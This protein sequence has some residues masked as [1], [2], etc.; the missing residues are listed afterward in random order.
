MTEQRRIAV[1]GAASNVG[2][3]PYDDGREARHLDTTAA[4]L[5]SLGVVGR[6]Q[7]DDLG[8]VPG[9]A[10]RDFQRPLGGVRNESE[11]AEYSRAL[12]T[13][14]ASAI[15]SGRFALVLG[16]DCSIVLGSLLG[17][18]HRGKRIGLAYLDGHSDFAT[19][20][21][22]ATG[23]AASMCLALAVGRGDSPLAALAGPAPLVH[24]YDV[25]LMGRRDDD[26]PYYGNAALAASP[27][28]DIPGPV[29]VA[30]PG[31][32]IAMAALHRLGRASVDGF[33]IHVDADVLDAGV[34]PAVD[35]PEPHGPGIDQ[36]AAILAPLVSHPKA[37]GMQI[38]I[39][40]PALDADRT[41]ASRLVELLEKTFATSAVE[42]AWSFEAGGVAP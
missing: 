7:A 35:S 27:I 10:Y 23:S 26:Q 24:P 13:R 12:A 21:E 18:R 39:Y 14:V 5:R 15:D 4:V 16:S 2:I 3:R 40:D 25:V 38:T 41:C 1:I 29:L 36:L 8:D 42:E 19:P 32:A 28:F 34:M 11:V 30:M 6:L 9:P 17:A 20:Q 33:W 37:L 31:G 22:S